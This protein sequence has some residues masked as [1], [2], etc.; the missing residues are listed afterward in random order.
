MNSILH[1]VPQWLI[2][3]S[4]ALGLTACG[5][6]GNDASLP[7]SAPAPSITAITY[8]SQAATPG[9]LAKTVQLL[10]AQGANG[11]AY[12]GNHA[13]GVQIDELFVKAQANAS[14]SYR[15]TPAATDTAQAWVEQLNT[16]GRNGFLLKNTVPLT[17]GAN[18]ANL[19]L[20]SNTESFTYSYKLVPG[21]F[22][23]AELNNQGALGYAYR[24]DRVV[25]TDRAT[26]MLFVK[27]DGSTAQFNYKTQPS[28]DDAAK[29]LAEMNTLGSQ[30]YVYLSSLFTTQGLVSLYEQNTS[31]TAATEFLSLPTEAATPTSALI[32]KANEQAAKGYYY[33]GDLGFSRG[34]QIISLFYKGQAASSHPINGPTF[35]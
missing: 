2:G 1:S 24:G 12:I 29:L 5:G 23:L 33:L 15:N 13:Y 21:Q 22:A 32:E 9:D 3:F 4:L 27:N 19:L 30:R 26:Y 6:G 17:G 18:A 16:E 20:K 25:G 35:P 10:N 11:Y 34:T 31:A 14:Y 8:I 28:I 7:V